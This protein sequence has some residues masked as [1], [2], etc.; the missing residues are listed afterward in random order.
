M[1]TILAIALG[2]SLST[3]CGF[4]IFIPPFVL[5]LAAIFGKVDLA[6]GLDWLGT[7]PA[8]IAFATAAGLETLGFCVPG[9][10]NLLDALA[11]PIALAMGTLV[12]AATL[13][14][15]IDPVIRWGVAAIAGGGST[16]IVQGTA[17]ITRLASNA[18]TGGLASPVTAIIESLSAVVLS[19][20]ALLVPLLALLIVGGILW[21]GFKKVTRWLNKQ[22]KSHER[23][24]R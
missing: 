22:K 23:V 20:L 4:R 5:S 19:I 7:Y 24:T 17:A 12:A 14:G 1:N 11:A 15:E 18:L 21:W 8:L 2:V 13:N 9:F 3:A 16:T 10:N 6:P